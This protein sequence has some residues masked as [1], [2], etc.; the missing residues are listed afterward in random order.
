MTGVGGHSSSTSLII[1][2][3]A[4]SGLRRGMYYNDDMNADKNVVVYTWR[5]TWDFEWR[6]DPHFGH[7][8]PRLP[9]SSRVFAVIV[10]LE[11]KQSSITGI[12]RALE[13]VAGS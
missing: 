13:L 6:G 9:P 10:Q 7:P 1:A 8:E 12:N 3:H 11:K 2:E 5:Q 4:F